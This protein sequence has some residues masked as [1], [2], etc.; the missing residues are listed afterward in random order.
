[1]SRHGQMAPESVA[2]ASCR[3]WPGSCKPGES[4][5]QAAGGR[6]RGKPQ[7][8]VAVSVVAPAV[9][10]TELSIHL[11]ERVHLL[12]VMQFVNDVFALQLGFRLQKILL[13]DVFSFVL[14]DFFH[15]YFKVA[16]QLCVL[17]NLK[18]MRHMERQ[19]LLQHLF[20]ELGV[21]VVAKMVVVVAGEIHVVLV[22]FQRR[23][24]D[25]ISVD[26]Q[27]LFDFVEHRRLLPPYPPFVP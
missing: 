18:Q 14:A 15:H 5:L 3:R 17:F 9:A 25:V 20:V 21:V 8:S 6:S 27:Q 23:Q 16:G 10:G 13:F 22:F 2:V 19:R 1:M 24:V 12:G 7:R 4:R 26:D 11:R